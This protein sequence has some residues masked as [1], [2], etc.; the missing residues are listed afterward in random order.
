MR[1]TGDEGRHAAKVRRVAIGRGGAARRRPRGGRGLCRHAGPRRRVSSSTSGLANACRCLTRARRG[2]TALAEGRSCRAGR[3]ADDRTGRRRDRAVA[4][5]TRS[6]VQW[7][8]GRDVRALERWRRTAREAAKQSRRPRVPVV[9]DPVTTAELARSLCVAMRTRAARGRDRSRSVARVAAAVRR[10]RARRR[11]GRRRDRRRAA[12]RSPRPGQSAVG[13]A[14]RSCGP[15]PQG[16][17]RA[18]RAVGTARPSGELIRRG[19]RRA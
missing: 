16:A 13:S 7:R 12:R 3:R 6:V 4:R 2:R 5:R 14:S 11:P 18:G 1:L 19:A 17:A 8:D 10:D 15:P 9:T